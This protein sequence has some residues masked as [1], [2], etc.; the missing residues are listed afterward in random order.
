MVS[1]SRFL[2]EGPDLHTMGNLFLNKVFLIVFDLCILIHFVSIMISYALAGPTAYG[3]FIFI[4]WKNQLSLY[5]L[6]PPFVIILALIVIFGAN[7]IGQV[8]SILTLFKGSMLVVMISVVG[9]VGFQVNHAYDDNWIFAGR[10]F[11]VGTVALGGA[12]NTL[13]LIYSKMSPTARN[14]GLFR[15]VSVL[16]LFVCWLL[17][18][19]WCWFILRIVPQ[20][21]DPA[22]PN[23]PTLE[24]SSQLG[25]PST[26]PLISILNTGKGNFGWIGYL[27]AVFIMVSITVSFMAMSSG[28]KHM[29][30]GWIKSFNSWTSKPNSYGHSIVRRCG[31]ISVWLQFSMYV[32]FFALVLILALLN[33][34]SFLVILEVFTSLALNME[35]GFFIAWMVWTS[36]RYYKQSIPLPLPNWFVYLTIW[37][38]GGYFLFACIWDVAY[39][40]TSLFVDPMPF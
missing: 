21:I 6:I 32:F 24:R 11:L 18:V 1:K 16:A 28:L 30:D 10:S 5:I 9:F 3:Q 7:F 38:C 31:S 20:S 25:E 14:I 8:I 34:K 23:A 26:V 39:H 22:N 17:N 37:F 2:S 29:L 35:S 27:V 15:F 12:V 4:L 36:K 33:P 19:L 40:V 13:P